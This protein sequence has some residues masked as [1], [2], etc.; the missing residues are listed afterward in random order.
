MCRGLTV[1]VDAVIAL[2]ALLLSGLAAVMPTLDS[3]W[4]SARPDFDDWGSALGE[5]VGPIDSLIPM[6]EV[7]SLLDVT[8]TYVL[9]AVV[10]Y[11]VVHWVYA[12][13]PMVG[14]G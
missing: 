8:F 6:S 7:F 10:L 12:H 9:P 3:A 2:A 4:S 14:K 13:L 5:R 1:V 11:S